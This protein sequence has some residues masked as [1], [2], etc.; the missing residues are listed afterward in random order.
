[1]QWS[2]VKIFGEMYTLSLIYSYVAVC[3]F[4]IISCVIIICFPLLFSNYLTYVFNILLMSVFLFCIFVFYFVYSVFLYCFVYNFSFSIH[5]CPLSYFC[6][7]LLTTSTGWRPNCSKQISYH[8]TCLT[9]YG[10]INYSQYWDKSRRF[11]VNCTIIS[12]HQFLW[13]T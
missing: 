3:R 6:T 5:S 11:T 10:V 1:V 13:T 2:E 9:A 7:S 12:H 8:I 4:C